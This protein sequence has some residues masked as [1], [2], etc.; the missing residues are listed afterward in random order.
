V[1][2]SPQEPTARR[3]VRVKHPGIG[4]PTLSCGFSRRSMRLPRAF[5]LH[6]PWARRA[7]RWQKCHSISSP[8]KGSSS[9][10]ICPKHRPPEMPGKDR[11]THKR[12]ADVIPGDTTPTTLPP[13]PCSQ[14]NL[15]SEHALL[16]SPFV[17]GDRK[18]ETG[19][20][21]WTGKAQSSQPKHTH[22][23]KA[24]H[25]RWL[26]T[27]KTMEPGRYESCSFS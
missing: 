27:A 21:A 16:S 9:V 22:H 5:F 25:T 3:G 19:S 7:A 14:K 8:A 15:S 17:V 6:R 18:F 23:H 4:S 20:T 1:R 10:L 13:C 11:D 24:T 26:L 2:S 12:S